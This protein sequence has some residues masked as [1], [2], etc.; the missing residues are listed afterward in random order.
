LVIE[1]YEELVE[2]LECILT[3]ERRD[4]LFACHD[5]SY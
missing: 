3:E 5:F 4:E 2:V 1:T